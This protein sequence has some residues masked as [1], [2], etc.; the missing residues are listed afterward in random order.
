MIHPEDKHKSKISFDDAYNKQ[1]PFKHEVR[2]KNKVGKYRWHNSLAHPVKDSSGQIVKWIGVLTD[3][4]DQKTAQQ[5]IK[6]LLEK[7]DEF[8]SIASHELKTPVTSMKALL[9]LTE[10]LLREK[11]DAAVVQSFIL[12]ANTHVNKITGLI[13]DLLDVTKIQAGKI[14]LNK[15]H[16]SVESIIHDATEQVPFINQSHKLIIKGNTSHELYADRHRLDQVLNN[17]ISNAVKYSPN[18]D[19]IILQIEKIN[20]DLKFIVTDFGMGIPQDKIPYV[21]DRFF[22][23]EESTH[24][25]SGLG[26]G[27]YISAEIVRRH[28]GKIGVESEPGK[29]S[30]F[31]FTVP[32]TEPN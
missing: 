27:L 11:G 25:V 21:F 30:S 17:L 8:I 9:Q 13:E 20:N 32:C 22:R 16:F 6:T 4:E 23:V 7:K 24:M 14:V 18:A 10:R 3:I 12:K 26:L 5:A 1:I 29:G 15:S 28:G 19:S 31:W 2:L